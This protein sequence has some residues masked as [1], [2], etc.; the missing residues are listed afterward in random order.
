MIVR[1]RPPVRVNQLKLEPCQHLPS[2]T[3]TRVLAKGSTS[4]Q[5]MINI[6]P[7]GTHAYIIYHALCQ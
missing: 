1:T 4:K 7:L 3:P 2:S 5:V 6:P